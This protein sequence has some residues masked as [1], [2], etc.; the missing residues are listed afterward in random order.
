VKITGIVAIALLVGA[1]AA[2][3]STAGPSSPAIAPSA[4][5][6]S[7]QTPAAS[8]NAS[9]NPE[10]TSASPGPS[11]SSPVPSPTVGASPS[12]ISSPAVTPTPSSDARFVGI[13]LAYASRAGFDLAADPR[14]KVREEEPDFERV[15]LHR[16]A[17]R[18]AHADGAKL[19][20]FLDDDGAIK[21]VEDGLYN[22]PTGAP[23]SRTA[24]LRAAR[25]YLR[26]IGVDPASGTLHVAQHGAGH[27]YLTFD[28]EIAGYPVANAPMAWWITGDK[29][30][31]E[32]GP[33]ASLVEIYAIRPGHLPVP[34]ILARDTLDRRLAKVAKVTRT[35]LA[36]YDPALLWV[37]VP[38]PLTTLPNPELTLN[39]CA[40]KRTET[41]WQVWCVDAGTGERTVVGDAYD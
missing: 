5:P 25:R 23:A 34:T 37:L 20:V 22:R 17:L 39:Y 33:D 40:T 13:A 30:Y 2:P 35:T 15:T 7:S 26:Q 1:C 9:L 38:Q 19:R 10:L 27:W 4:V 29:A 36:T 11:T 12:P 18:L 16:V 14:P 41:S 31:L 32:L 24:V 21:V 8:E 28:R 6:T 3:T